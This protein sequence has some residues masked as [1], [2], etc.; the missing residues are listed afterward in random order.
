M[1]RLRMKVLAAAETDGLETNTCTD[2][3][4]TWLPEGRLVASA[5]PKDRLIAISRFTVSMLNVTV[6]HALVGSWFWLRMSQ[7]PVAPQY[8]VCRASVGQSLLALEQ[9]LTS[10]SMAPDPLLLASNRTNP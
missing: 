4:V 9:K 8:P 6:V 5:F 1:T 10:G 3:Q 7:I 2:G